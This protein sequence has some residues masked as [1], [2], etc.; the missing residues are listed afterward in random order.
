MR[1]SSAGQSAVP[2]PAGRDRRPQRVVAAAPPGGSSA[3]A[4]SAPSSSRRA[5]APSPAP[6]REQRQ[7]RQ[8]GSLR[9][10]PPVRHDGLEDRL[11]H[12]RGPH[13]EA[14]RRGSG[15]GSA[16]SRHREPRRARAS[17]ARVR[18]HRS[19]RSDGAGDQRDEH[20]VPDAAVGETG[21]DAPPRRPPGPGSPAS[22]MRDRRPPGRERVLPPPASPRRRPRRAP[23]RD[24][25][26][27]RRRTRATERRT[28]PC[29]RTDPGDVLPRV[30][31]RRAGQHQRGA[32]L[33][34]VEVPQRSATRRAAVVDAVE[35]EV[36]GRGDDPDQDVPERVRRRLAEVPGGA[37]A[38]GRSSTARV[39]VGVE[40]E[41]AAA[42][43]VPAEVR[44][45]RPGE[46]RSVG[47]RPRGAAGRR[48]RRARPRRAAAAGSRRRRCPAAG[49]RV[50]EGRARGS[51]AGSLTRSV[52]VCMASAHPTRAAA[53]GRP[54]ADLCTQR[55]R[56]QGHVGVSVRSACGYPVAVP[57]PA[58][59]S[60]RVRSGLVAAV[61]AL[62]V[63]VST[64]ACSTSSPGEASPTGSAVALATPE[65]A[66]RRRCSRRPTATR[67]RGGRA[68]RR[69]P[70]R[71]HPG[72]GRR[73]GARSRRPR[74]STA[75]TS[76]RSA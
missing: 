40:H 76:P 24:R 15:R 62:A 34:R 69:L 47:R 68:R 3:S 53:G 74:P 28:S 58:P 11:V 27:H 59:L 25:R 75:P 35:R 21:L 36:A 54:S 14:R 39:L 64:A 23:P 71:T 51:R 22:T 9:A 12:R 18:T 46:Q 57:R 66:P 49:S 13:R 48:G 41:D 33:R 56:T 45:E 32:D 50:D 42:G 26:S 10:R 38:R 2:D 44:D 5:R 37:A 43:P 17:T 31:D 67:L 7:Q 73:R 29:S 61:V 4:S 19:G 52:V 55:R 60:A 1:I 6:P 30:R 8:R 72:A 16:P 20:A 70:R 63:G 65:P